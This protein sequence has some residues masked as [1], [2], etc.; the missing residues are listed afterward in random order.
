MY[1]LGIL[2]AA[3]PAVL[4]AGAQEPAELGTRL[5]P[6]WDTWLI[7]DMDGAALE[8][9]PPVLREVVLTLD[10][11][12]EGNTSTYF[13]V[14]PDGGKFRMY[15][16]GSNYN[17][18]TREHK[19]QRIC[20]AE[21]EDGI[22]W[23]KPELGLF[24]WEG[25]K[26]NN[27]IWTGDGEHNFTPFKD[28][29][30]DCPPEARYKAVGSVHDDGRHGLV[31]FQ[32]ADA[33]HWEL[34]RQE[35][36]ITE[37]A[38]DSQNLVFW[39][40][41]R[42]EYRE[43]HRGFRDGVRAIMTATTRDFLDW[44][45][46]EWLVYPEG[47][48]KEHL[49]TNAITPYPRAPHLFVGFPKRFLPGRDLGVHPNPGVSDG[50]FMTSRDGLR[51]HRWREALL[52]PGPDPTRWVNRNNMI[53]W[54]IA[55]TASGDPNLPDE[56]SIYSTEG[57]YVGPCELRR[58][59][60]RIDGFASVSASATGGEFTT[61][62]LTFSDG[63]DPQPVAQG[64]QPVERVAEGAPRGSG[65]LR[66]ER[67]HALDLPDTVSLGEQATLAVWVKNMPAGHRRLFSA[68]DGGAVETTQ[69]ELYFDC[70]AGGEVGKSGAAIRFC[71]NT[72]MAEAPADAVNPWAKDSA[73]HHLAATYDEGRI[74]IYFDGAEV[75]RGG[76]EG[77]G[78]MAFRH[79]GLRFG[80]DFP[81]ASLTNEPFLGI[82]DDILVLRRALAPEE[83]RRL[84]AENAEA[85]LAEDD[86]GLLYTME[87]GGAGSVANQMPGAGPDTA[88]ALLPE[89]AEVK[90]LLNYATSAAGTIR[91][92]LQDAAGAPIPGFTLEDCDPIY[93]DHI[94]RVATWNGR[95][96][97][98]DL[99]GAPV[100]L[101]VTLADAELY[102][103]RFR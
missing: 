9:H 42:G 53:A 14:M 51:F 45:D 43:Y 95:A 101:R 57:Y 3:A 99:A 70:D 55:R 11:P 74:R 5:E 4:G 92:E 46:P 96:E 59:T 80:E 12:W 97:L 60:V 81:P 19:G 84:A 13:T 69:G 62:P 36:I 68:Y 88:L 78:P 67:A 85:V 86:R 41:E 93:G 91:C 40:A 27:I 31:A 32:S 23:T 39:D 37:G 50:V 25:S 49:Y 22:H 16:R 33:I 73:P 100:R 24:E 15:Y 103:I 64:P 7:D 6:L 56:L 26:A 83:V 66:F 17:L 44:P 1:C 75:G 29:N 61:R 34:M 71:Y 8:L 48:P 47:T 30:P 58:H 35:P 102:A 72:V 2:L 98:K 87:D 28:G 54:G 77:G 20:Y 52:P 21:S 89:A 90:L 38:F 65:A 63:E 82:A 79:G 18:E 10:A 94:E 76:A